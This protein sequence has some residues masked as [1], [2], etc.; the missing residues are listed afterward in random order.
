MFKSNSESFKSNFSIL[1]NI[2]I[3]LS[4]RTPI[5]S[6]IRKDWKRTMSDKL[7]KRINKFRERR[8]D[9]FRNKKIEIFNELNESLEEYNQE[10][11]EHTELLHIYYEKLIS[12]FDLENK[13][14]FNLEIG[15]AENISYCPY[16]SYPVVQI[17]NKVLCLNL[18]FDFTISDK[19]ENFNFTNFLDVYRN[20]YNIHKDCYGIIDISEIDND[21]FLRCKQ[22]YE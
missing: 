18:C 9:D 12:I 5:Q 13:D 11:A 19:I 22:C 2:D 3:D 6:T 21:I 4:H 10:I 1:P 16:C 7:I 20:Y 8:I 17:Y 15:D 14:K